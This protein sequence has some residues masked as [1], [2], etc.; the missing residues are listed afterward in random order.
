MPHHTDGLRFVPA[1]QLAC[2]D[3]DNDLKRVELR[4]ADDQALGHL[5]GV[6][7]D[8]AA[9]RVRYFVVENVHW[10]TRR[11]YLLPHC[12]ASVGVNAH[13]LRLECA[14][15][16]SPESFDANHIPRFSDD[17]LIDSMFAASAAA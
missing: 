13:V 12:P 10:L 7:V 9:R 14:E 1:A 16:D 2:G 15:P 6:V 11:R 3:G 8:P 17:D 5:H 4:G